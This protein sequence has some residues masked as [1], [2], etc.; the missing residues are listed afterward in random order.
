MLRVSVIERVDTVSATTFQSFP[1]LSCG[2]HR[3]HTYARTHGWP[4]F[5]CARAR[6]L[7]SGVYLV[8]TAAWKVSLSRAETGRE[9]Y[10]AG[11]SFET[12]FSSDS[13]TRTHT[14]CSETLLFTYVESSMKEY[15]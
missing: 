10:Q 4:C 9:K 8:L 5:A 3:E 14:G 2:S 7:F 6:A 11:N 12:K 13:A 15:L 1:Y